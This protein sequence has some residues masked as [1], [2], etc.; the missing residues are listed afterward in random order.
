MR[1]RAGNRDCPLD[2]AARLDLLCRSE[3]SCNGPRVRDRVRNHEV[4]LQVYERCQEPRALDTGLLHKVLGGL[5]TRDT[6]DVRK[7]CRRPLG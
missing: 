3:D 1:V 4:R 7:P 6:R 2:P 5:A